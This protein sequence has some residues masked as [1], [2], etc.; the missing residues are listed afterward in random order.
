MTSGR[1]FKHHSCH[2]GHG[3]VIK[4]ST[5][6]WFC[7]YCNVGSLLFELH[8][9]ALMH[10]VCSSIIINVTE[11]SRS[12]ASGS[13]RRSGA[14]SLRA[15]AAL[16]RRRC[17]PACANSPPH[18]ARPPRLAGSASYAL[19]VRTLATGTATHQRSA[20]VAPKGGPR[21]RRRGRG[22]RLLAGLVLGTRGWE[23]DYTDGTNDTL[24]TRQDISHHRD[25]ARQLSY[26]ETERPKKILTVYVGKCIWL[27][28]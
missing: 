5:L 28:I 23:I 18:P 12:S 2:L 26:T 14:C 17:P 24:Y 21:A 19:P 27:I 7:E 4:N 20:L 15:V 1:E 6:F 11:F 22:P 8:S 3:L 9:I 10:L 25:C 13:A 16:V